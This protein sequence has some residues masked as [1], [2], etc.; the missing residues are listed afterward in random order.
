MVHDLDARVTPSL[1]TSGRSASRVWMVRNG[2][3]SRI[4]RSRPRSRLPGGTPSERRDPR[5]CISVGRPPKMP[6]VD[7]EPKR[8]EDSR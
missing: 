5:V 2:A 6:V 8:G 7:I 3:K 4:L 1:R